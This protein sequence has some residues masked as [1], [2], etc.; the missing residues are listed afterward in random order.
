MP[1]MASA[2]GEG[3]ASDVALVPEQ[4]AA[5]TPNDSTSSRVGARIVTAPFDDRNVRSLST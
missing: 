3:E 2:D 4:A 1:A 5:T